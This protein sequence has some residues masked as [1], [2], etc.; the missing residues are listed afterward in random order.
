ME[1]SASS[2]GSHTP[3]WQQAIWSGAGGGLLLTIVVLLAFSALTVWRIVDTIALQQQGDLYFV[4]AGIGLV[5]HS[6][7]RLLAILV[8]A[9][10]SFAGLAISFF[11]HA[12]ATTAQIT[13][14]SK[15]E[16]ISPAAFNGT[17]STY[18]PGLVGVVVGASVIACALFATSTHTY[19]PPQHAVLPVAPGIAASEPAGYR[20]KTIDELRND[21]A[22]SINKS[23]SG[24]K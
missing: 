8:G 24:P 16:A 3:R 14:G 13:I 15:A 4:F 22:T 6:L 23:A 9:A 12:Q 18:A 2:N 21:E 19:K 20:P 1:N 7:L 5:T 10:I 11:A 17:L